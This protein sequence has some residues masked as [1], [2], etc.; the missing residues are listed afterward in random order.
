MNQH[1]SSST[2]CGSVLRS[3]IFFS[4]TWSP[5]HIAMFLRKQEWEN[6]LFPPLPSSS[7]WCQVSWAEPPGCWLNSARCGICWGWKLIF[8]VLTVQTV[9]LPSLW[10]CCSH[11]HRLSSSKTL[12]DD[13][14]YPNSSLSLECNTDTN[15]LS[16][17]SIWGP[18][19]MLSQT[20]NPLN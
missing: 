1:P 9:Q 14:E 4:A 2:K 6:S 11:C 5:Q 8:Q 17:I 19:D 12:W 16:H 15:I 3:Y 7:S 18:M 10:S 20:L 13:S